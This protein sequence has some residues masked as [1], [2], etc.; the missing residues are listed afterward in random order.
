MARFSVGQT[1]WA[2]KDLVSKASEDHPA[3]RFARYG[4]SLLVVE[5]GPEETMGY[6]VSRFPDRREPFW[7]HSSELMGQ[8][9]LPGN[10]KDYDWN[11]AFGSIGK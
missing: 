11:K 8:A 6:C 9:P 4:D 7:C 3:M 5:V 2:G 10:N 1:V